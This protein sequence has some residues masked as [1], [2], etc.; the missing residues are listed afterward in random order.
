MLLHTHSFLLPAYCLSCTFLASRSMIAQ[1][2]IFFVFPNEKCMFLKI[3]GHLFHLDR[4]GPSGRQR[5]PPRCPQ[6]PSAST[7]ESHC[8]HARVAILGPQRRCGAGG[9]ARTFHFP[10]GNVAPVAATATFLQDH[11]KPREATGGYGRPREATGDHG[12]PREV[13]GGHAVT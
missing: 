6:E 12:R 10:H 7:L 5:A 4:Q 1:V 8:R 2:S 11:G 13:T 3:K 9:G